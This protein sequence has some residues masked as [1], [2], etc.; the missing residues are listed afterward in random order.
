MQ[1]TFQFMTLREV[2]E[3]H[4]ILAASEL[5]RRIVDEHGQPKLSR[6]QAHNLW[7]GKAGVGK[8]TMRMLHDSLGI[9]YDELMEVD[10]VPSPRTRKTETPEDFAPPEGMKPPKNGRRGKGRNQRRP[11]S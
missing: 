7:R 11:R 4:G 10:P 1:T 6:A 8:E 2:L 9:S 3:R 5:R